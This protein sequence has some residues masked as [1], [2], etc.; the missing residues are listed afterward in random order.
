[1]ETSS[2]LWGPVGITAALVCRLLGTVLLRL[3]SQNGRLVPVGVEIEHGLDAR[4]SHDLLQDPARAMRVLASGPR[5]SEL[6]TV[7][8]LATGNSKKE[9]VRRDIKKGAG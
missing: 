6:L 5:R 7:W 2:R 1:M 9:R 8:R 3:W 4:M